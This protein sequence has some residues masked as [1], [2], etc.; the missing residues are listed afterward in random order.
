MYRQPDYVGVRGRDQGKDNVVESS[1]CPW[2]CCG[3]FVPSNRR[4]MHDGKVFAETMT[5]NGWL[6]LDLHNSSPLI[7][8]LIRSYSATGVCVVHLA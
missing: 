8:S 6:F 4:C 5:C 1:A 7:Y 2:A 3:I